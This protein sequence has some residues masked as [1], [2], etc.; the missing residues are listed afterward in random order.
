MICVLS[1]NN[2]RVSFRIWSTL[3]VLKATRTND[4]L[5][6]LKVL[7]LLRSDLTVKRKETYRL[8]WKILSSYDFLLAYF[9]HTFFFFF[10]FTLQIAIYYCPTIFLRSIVLLIKLYVYSKIYRDFSTTVDMA[11]NYWFYSFPSCIR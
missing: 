4:M 10:F 5:L 2:Q 7:L 11:P 9:L 1:I 8:L 6:L 3:N